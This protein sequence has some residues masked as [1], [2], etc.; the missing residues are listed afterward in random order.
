MEAPGAAAPADGGTVGRN[1]AGGA[2][3]ALEW[4]LCGMLVA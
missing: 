2:G 3:S 4:A 1:Q